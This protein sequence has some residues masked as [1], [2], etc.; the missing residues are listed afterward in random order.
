ME[1]KTIEKKIEFLPACLYTAFLCAY[2]CMHI[3]Y[4]R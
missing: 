2:E 3:V 1:E 4:T